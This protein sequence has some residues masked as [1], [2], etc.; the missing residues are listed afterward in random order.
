MGKK[1]SIDDYKIVSFHVSDR[2]EKKYYVIVQS[3]SNPEE[4]HRIYFGAI[5]PDGTPYAQFRDLTPLKHYAKYDHGN[6]KRLENYQK[7]HGPFDP[8]YITP[9]TLSYLFLWAD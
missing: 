8:D 9:N 1:F 4:Q 6:P 3:K 2:S 7:R 5:K